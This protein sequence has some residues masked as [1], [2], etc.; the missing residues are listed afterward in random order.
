MENIKYRR[1]D[2]KDLVTLYKFEQA[3]VATERPFDP[4]LKPGH[5][6]DY[7]IKAMIDDND[8]EV[9]IA[10]VDLEIVGSGYVK[11]S[12][13]KSY[14]NFEKYAYAGFMYV[15]PGYRRKGISQTIIEKLKSWAKSKNV[16]ELRL[17]VYDENHIAV[18]AYE[19]IGLQKHLVEMRMKI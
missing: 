6:N 17:D 19:K 8:T 2:I 11:I 1:A 16:N 18:A 5:I 7:D 4:T 10:E 14:L 12:N 9:I 3:I 13:A 15:K